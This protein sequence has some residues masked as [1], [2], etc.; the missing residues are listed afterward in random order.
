MLHAEP[1][2]VAVTLRTEVFLRERAG[3]VLGSPAPPLAYSQTIPRS[4]LTIYERKL[5]PRET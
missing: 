1:I 5:V 2:G 4:E 3:S